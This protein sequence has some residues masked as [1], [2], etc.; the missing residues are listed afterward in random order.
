VIPTHVQFFTR[1]SMRALLE[2]EGWTVLHMGTQPKIF[3]VRYYLGRIGG[4]VPALGRFLV[5]GAETV[6]VA[7]RLWGPDFR[8]R[9]LVV[10]RRPG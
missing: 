6:R 7:D 1:P 5:K 4:Y 10:A 2:R 3:T 8:D 9:M